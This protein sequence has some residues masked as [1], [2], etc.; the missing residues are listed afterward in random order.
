VRHRRLDILKAS[1]R[2]MI[3]EHYASGLRAQ[4]VADRLS[5]QIATAGHVPA[6]RALS[7]IEAGW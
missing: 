5:Q 6:H 4:Q 1:L 2:Q 7:C 3:L